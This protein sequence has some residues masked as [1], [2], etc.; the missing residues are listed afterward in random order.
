MSNLVLNG[1]SNMSGGTFEEVDVDGVITIKGD[2]ICDTMEV[3]GIFKVRGNTHIKEKMEVDGVCKIF[4][5]LNAE[6]MDIEGV[7]TVYGNVTA[8]SAKI[9]GAIKLDGTFN[10]GLLDLK[11]F[12]SPDIKEIVGGKIHIRNGT[13]RWY[14]KA[15]LIEGDDVHVERSKVKLI[16]GDNVIIGAGC[17][18]DRVEYRSGLEIHPKSRVKEKIVLS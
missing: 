8:E 11:F 7:L 9:E 5:D 10:V 18:V 14:F 4:G 2:L 1:K 6:N 16:R 17:T 3:D 13:K 15:E 12:N